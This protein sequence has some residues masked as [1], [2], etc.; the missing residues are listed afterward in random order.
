MHGDYDVKS[1]EPLEIFSKDGM[2][3]GCTRTAKKY[4]CSDVLERDC[5]ESS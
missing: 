1:E 2:I 3:R 4:S 5:G